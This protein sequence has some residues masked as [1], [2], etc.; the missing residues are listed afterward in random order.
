M[1]GGYFCICIPPYVKGFIVFIVCNTL[2]LSMI[3]LTKFFFECLVLCFFYREVVSLSYPLS[4]SYLCLI[5]LMKFIFTKLVDEKVIDFMVY[6]HQCQNFYAC[7]RVLC[8]TRFYFGGHL[9]SGLFCLSSQ[10]TKS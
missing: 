4:P 1:F 9:M 5:S 2:Y 7:V 3:A 10:S 6:V 8:L